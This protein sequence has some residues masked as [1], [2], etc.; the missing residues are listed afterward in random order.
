MNV[1]KK[2]GTAVR[3]KLIHMR[4]KLNDISRRNRSIRLLKM[5]N[6]W[7]FDLTQLDQI[8]PVSDSIVK[9]IVTQSKQE[10]PLLKPTID[11]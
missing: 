3:E 4:D 2:V 6:K 7:S 9:K 1:H 8:S 10:I 11:N 5:Y